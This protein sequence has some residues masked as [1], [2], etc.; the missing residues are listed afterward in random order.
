MPSQQR[1]PCHLGDSEQ[2]HW[3]VII[4]I[5]PHFLHR[6]ERNSTP[7]LDYGFRAGCSSREQ[8]AW[9]LHSDPASQHVG[10]EGRPLIKAEGHEGVAATRV[11]LGQK[12]L[13]CRQQ[14]LR[15]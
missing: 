12:A 8:L 7:K 14:M 1:Y 15:T 6:Y 2:R 9:R 13:D 4:S 3:L 10:I 5:I 11:L